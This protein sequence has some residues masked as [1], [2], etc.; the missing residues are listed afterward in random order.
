VPLPAGVPP[1]TPVEAAAATP[2]GYV[3]LP[4]GAPATTPVA[5]LGNTKFAQKFGM[6]GLKPIVTSKPAGA[7]DPST[8]A[9][10]AAKKESFTGRLFGK[11]LGRK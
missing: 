11:L 10:P 6:G 7:A 5:S 9:A 1:T 4:P 8:P 2:S 3:Q